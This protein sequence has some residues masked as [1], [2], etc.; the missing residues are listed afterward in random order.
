[1]GKGFTPHNVWPQNSM[2]SI[3]KKEKEK[4]EEL[5]NSISSSIFEPKEKQ[6]EA[7]LTNALAPLLEAINKLV[8]TKTLENDVDEDL[9]KKLDLSKRNE[10]FLLLA[11]LIIGILAFISFL[12]A[13][14][15]A[16]S[17]EKLLR[18]IYK[19]KQSKM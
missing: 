3:L 5:S 15:S 14:W 6:D 16:S 11:L 7:K 4:E 19:L 9:Q 2:P 17:V 10:K 8:T 1:M 18:I 12:S 13:I